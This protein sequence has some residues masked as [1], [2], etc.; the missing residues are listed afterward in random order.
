[1]KSMKSSSMKSM[2]SSKSASK[3]SSKSSKSTAALTTL[4]SFTI[5]KFPGLSD[6]D[7][8]AAVLSVLA[9][10]L[11]DR[12]RLEE[13]PS[14]S[15]DDTF[16]VWEI[17]ILNTGCSLNPEESCLEVTFSAED[18]TTILNTISI[19]DLISFV[20]AE[21]ISV[22][23]PDGYD[24]SGEGS[25]E[26]IVCSETTEDPTFFPT[27]EPTFAPIPFNSTNTTV[28]RFLENGGH[29]LDWDDREEEEEQRIE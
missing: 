10:L 26:E 23:L 6:A 19:G 7:L 27:F 11:S 3:K 2:K 17:G 18:S 29:F 12:R 16:G 1:M 5:S 21:I 15:L 22:I 9:S 14:D 24:C 20:I 13:S 4:F 8:E 28:T 25:F